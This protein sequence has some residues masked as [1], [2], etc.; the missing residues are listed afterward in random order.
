[1]FDQKKIFRTILVGLIFLLMLLP[2][3]VTFNDVLTRIVQ[4]NALY[5]FIERHVVPMEAKMMGTLMIA[6]GYSF[7]F[8]PSNS[9]MVVNGIPIQISWNCLGWQSMFLLLLTFFLGLRGKYKKI[10]ILEVLVIGILGTFWVNII[11]MMT[12]VILAIHARPIFRIVFHDYLAAVVSIVWLFFFWWF[13]YRYLLEP[14][15]VENV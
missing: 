1:M 2:F 4:G 10:G 9:V 11:R 8:S 12:T 15:E 3:M 13:S 14:V 7:S 5:L 6:L